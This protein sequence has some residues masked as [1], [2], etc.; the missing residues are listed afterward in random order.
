MAP[1]IALVTVTLVARLL[2]WLGVES[3]AYTTTWPGSAAVG[4]AA[5]FL[6]AAS[7][8]VLPR[9]RAG[10]VAIVPPKVPAPAAFV[11]VTGGLEVAG[12]IGLLLPP[13]L[14]PGIRA[15]A[16]IG[17]GLLLLAMFPANVYAA[18]RRR[19]PDAPDTPLMR[20]TVMQLIYLG[21]VIIVAFDAI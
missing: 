3:P 19:H 10:L 7:A 16:A 5:M 14:I 4:L 13:G 18:G 11:T 9:R 12:A 15:A 8:H 20:R 21:A 2:G 1:L 6:V 17:L